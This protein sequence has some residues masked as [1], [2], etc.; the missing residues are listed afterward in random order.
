M[1]SLEIHIK[2]D[3]CF[4]AWKLPVT[5]CYLLYSTFHTC[6]RADKHVAVSYALQVNGR[7]LSSNM[8]KYMAYP[9]CSTVSPLV[10]PCYLTRE[11]CVEISFQSCIYPWRIYRQLRKNMSKCALTGI[12][13]HNYKN[14]FY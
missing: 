7:H 2:S 3:K 14:K 11:T 8:F 6:I 12:M 4:M 9:E 1:Y 13:K 10:S 5:V